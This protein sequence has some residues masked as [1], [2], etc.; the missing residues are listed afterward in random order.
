M[1]RFLKDMKKYKEYAIYSA[2]SGLK[3]EVANSHLSWLWW[4][5]DPL[6]F[7]IV[8]SFLA[9]IVFGKSE[10][11]FAAFV[12]IGL[13]CWDFFSK[14]VKQS[15][16]IVSKNSSIV[17]KVYMPKYILIIIQMMSNAFKMFISYIL[18]VGIMLLY[19]VPVTYK[20]IYIIPLF[21]TLFMITFGVSTIFLHFGVFVE[22][23]YNVINVLLKFVF[24]LSG[25]FYSIGKRVPAPY[26]EILLKLNP[27]AFLMDSLRKCM[28][29]STTPNM[30]LVL[31]W[32]L[33][34]LLLA[35]IG[36]RT[37]YKSENTYVK[38]M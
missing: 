36:I 21:L 12:F 2:K 9:V 22:D 28:I 1:E 10:Q 27:V 37:I 29:Y 15:V 14:T 3:A 23:L 16:K 4:I 25:I 13:S 34:G 26:S 30:I 8:Y 32:F 31:V 35:G 38:V 5:L 24:Y 17:S 33:I 20:I 19:W 6:L 7:M 18:V 11:Y